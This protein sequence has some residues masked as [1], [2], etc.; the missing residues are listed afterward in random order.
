MEASYAQRL[1]EKGIGLNQPLDRIY[2]EIFSRSLYHLSQAI[3][4]GDASDAV[5]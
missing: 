1:V 2:T 5:P 3:L 4:R